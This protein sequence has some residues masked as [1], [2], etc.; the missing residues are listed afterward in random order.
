MADQAA[1]LRLGQRIG[2]YLL[3]S[4]IGRGG[5]GTVYRAEHVYLK[6]PVAV[7]VLH[8]SYFDQPDA[9]DRF[10]REAQTAGRIDHPNIVGVTDFGEAPTAPCSW[11]WPT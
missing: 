3:R 2:N 1:D 4:V 7:K 10:L 5:M 8:R 9:L 6:R 11:S